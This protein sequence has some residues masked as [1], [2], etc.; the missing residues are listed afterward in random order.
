[1]DCDDEPAYP[2]FPPNGLTSGC[3]VP[4]SSFDRPISESSDTEAS[5]SYED[6]PFSDNNDSS[7][8]P[9]SYVH[10]VEELQGQERVQ[11]RTTGSR[12]SQVHF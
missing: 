9:Q 11:E 1:M 10:S 6:T 5:Q 4:T 7:A 12:N 2:P 3:P 8:G